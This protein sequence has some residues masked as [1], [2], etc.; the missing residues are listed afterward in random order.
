MSKYFFEQIYFRVNIF[1]SKYFLEQKN[2]RGNVFSANLFKQLLE[3][4]ISSNIPQF[5][6]ED[7][8]EINNLMTNLRKL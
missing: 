2:Y 5:V 6:E 4:I 3:K 8:S 1:S 7:N